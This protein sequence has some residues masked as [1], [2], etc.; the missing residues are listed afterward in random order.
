MHNCY[1]DG[2]CSRI[3][4]VL[5]GPSTRV[6]R[7]CMTQLK[8]SIDDSL[9]KK[10]KQ[11][12]LAKRGKIELTSEGEDAI[13]LYIEK[14]EHLMEGRKTRESD[15]LARI[16]GAIRSKRRRNALE[17]LKELESERL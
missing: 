2:S 13:R 1:L 10:F 7:N 16:I 5:K 12:V 4:K 17:D 3:N 14:H 6:P 11:I 15:P 8:F 9:V